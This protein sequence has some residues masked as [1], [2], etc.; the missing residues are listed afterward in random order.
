M[1]VFVR[2]RWSLGETRLDRTN[3]RRFASR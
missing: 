1:P 3:W 2:P